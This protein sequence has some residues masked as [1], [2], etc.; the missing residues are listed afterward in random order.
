MCMYCMY[1]FI[2][3]CICMYDLYEPN[4]VLVHHFLQSMYS[5]LG[6]VGHTVT[7]APE[8]GC[9]SEKPMRFW[10]SIMCRKGAAL[11]NAIS[12]CYCNAL[13]YIHTNTYTY[14]H[15]HAYTLTYILIW[16]DTYMIQAYTHRYNIVCVCI[17]VH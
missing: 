10:Y 2:F 13:K 9:S 3:V 7:Y 11:G 17:C 5:H 16:Y 1:M 4:L 12:F 15:I 8:G 6:L 14:V